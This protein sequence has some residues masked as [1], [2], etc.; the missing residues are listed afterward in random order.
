MW[1]CNT[2]RVLTP[3][4]FVGQFIVRAVSTVLTLLV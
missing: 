2:F 3:F 1:V 4:V